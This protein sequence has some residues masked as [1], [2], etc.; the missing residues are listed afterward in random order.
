M[1]Q[2]RGKKLR[3]R[4][5]I[6]QNQYT[7]D[8]AGNQQ[9]NWVP[10]VTVFADAWFVSDAERIRTDQ[11]QTDTVIRFRVKISQIIRQTATKD[12][13]KYMSQSFAI[14]GI[15]VLD[16]RRHFEITASRIS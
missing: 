5:T 8:A 6:E 10:L 4:I 7:R 1:A 13:V 15:K 3:D 9:D 14:N 12:R 11:V 2:R 16:N